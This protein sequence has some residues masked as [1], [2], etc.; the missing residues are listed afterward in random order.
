MHF[1]KLVHF[2]HRESLP[3]AYLIAAL[4]GFSVGFCLLMIFSLPRQLMFMLIIMALCSFAIMIIGDIRKP[5]IAIIILDVPFQ[6]DIYLSFQEEA[7]LLG[8]IPGY[9]IS[10]TTICLTVLYLFWLFKIFTKQVS[11]PSN[12]LRS[13]LPLGAYLILVTLSLLRAKN[14]SLALFEISMLF[15]L[16]LLFV[17]IIGTIRTENEIL[18]IIAI[19]LMSVL[20]ESIIMIALRY[21]GQSI[22]FAGIFARIDSDMRVGG[23]VGSPNSAAAFLELLLVPALSV[24]ITRLRK[25]YKSLAFFAFFFGLVALVLTLSRGGWIAFII[26]ITCFYVFAWRCRWLTPFIPS[27]I[28]FAG[29]ILTVLFYDTITN[30]ILGYDLGAAYSRIPL[31]K[32]A[33][34]MI[35]ENFLLGIGANN[36]A[37]MMEEYSTKGFLGVWLYTVHNMYLLVAA[38][39]GIGGMVVFIWFLIETLRKGW[40]VYKL[41]HPLYSPIALSFTASIAGQMI[42]MT[43]DLFNG[44]PA[45]QGLCVIAALICVMRNAVEKL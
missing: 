12:L 19:L 18:F 11:L 3:T 30:R 31:M 25:A 17:Y 32:L 29:I 33:F 40:Q 34:N 6:V 37:F 28:L 1:S 21:I 45:M 5:L 26:S 36:F 2:S 35:K 22:E 15:Q 4:I 42:H 14:I 10:L 41:N 23:T 9:N 8:A 13:C 44:R 24:L 16:F 20:F 27:A 38:Q 39:T 43:V 7:A